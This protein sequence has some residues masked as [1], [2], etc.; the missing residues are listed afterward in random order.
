MASIT[1]HSQAGLRSFLLRTVAAQIHLVAGL[2]AVGGTFFLVRKCGQ[3]S[4]LNHVVATLL[5]GVTAVLLFSTSA[6]Y[7]FLFDG[8]RISKDLEDVFENLDHLAIYLFIAG[9]YTAVLINTV[10]NPWADYMLILIWTLAVLG[11]LYTFFRDRLPI[12]AQHR[13][14]YTGLFLSMGWVFTARAHEILSGFSHSGRIY[15]WLG[16]ACYTLGAVIYATKRPRLIEN[17]FGFHELWHLL[18]LCGFGFHYMLVL[19]FY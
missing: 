10:A 18:V 2:S 5:F 6:L 12:W 15:F 7:H 16:G 11:A 13:F 1:R 8:F 14:I 17:V 19:S 9:S 3:H 4:P